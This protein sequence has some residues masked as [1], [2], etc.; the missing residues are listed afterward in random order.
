MLISFEF[1]FG[2]FL[3]YSIGSQNV[4]PRPA[5]SAS[6]QNL[7][8]IQILSFTPETQIPQNPAGGTQSLCFNKPQVI[9]VFAAV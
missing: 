4:V 5:V 3:L 6:P 8:E 7:F 9:P 2:V 1:P